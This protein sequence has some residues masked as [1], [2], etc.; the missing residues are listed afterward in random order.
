MYVQSNWVLYQ[1]LTFLARLSCSPVRLERYAQVH[2]IV[3]RMLIGAQE[4]ENRLD[5]QTKQPSLL[6]HFSQMLCNYSD[7]L[8]KSYD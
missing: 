7:P 2:C 6:E 1:A 8:Q 3:L 5:I 4:V